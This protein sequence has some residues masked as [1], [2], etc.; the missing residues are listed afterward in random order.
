MGQDLTEHALAA[1]KAALGCPR[2][3][4]HHNVEG[5]E[6]DANWALEVRESL[7]RSSLL[8]PV[9]GR[10]RG[11]GGACKDGGAGCLV[12]LKD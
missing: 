1:A 11:R 4:A 9:V 6:A 8:R 2:L 12:S 10:G 5:Q 3:L 7:D